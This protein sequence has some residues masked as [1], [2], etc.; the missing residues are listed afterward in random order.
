MSVRRPARRVPA[1]LV[2]TLVGGLVGG[3]VAGCSGSEDDSAAACTPGSGATTTV[4]ADDRGVLP[5][6]NLVTVVSAKGDFRAR[7]A[8]LDTATRDSDPET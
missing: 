6:G 3:L 8:P 1:A 2:V 4:L 5:S 7:L